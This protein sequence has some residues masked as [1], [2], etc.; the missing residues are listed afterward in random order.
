MEDLVIEDGATSALEITLGDFLVFI[1]WMNQTEKSLDRAEPL[2][3]LP[4]LDS[5]KVRGWIQLVQ[6]LEERFRRSEEKKL[7]LEANVIAQEAQLGQLLSHLHTNIA[8][9]YE[10]LGQVQKAEDVRR[11]AEALHCA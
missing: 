6:R 2:P 5:A 11:R 4:N 3:A 10:N 9:L 7:A 1:N 8:S